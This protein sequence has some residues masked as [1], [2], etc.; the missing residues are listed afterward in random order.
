MLLQGQVNL[1]FW[2]ESSV[3]AVH[4]GRKAYPEAGRR[5]HCPGQPPR[6]SGNSVVLSS[7]L[8]ATI[9]TSKRRTT[10]SLP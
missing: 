2:R 3:P 8:S 5:P 7:S 9:G 10:G 1:A 4:A 6:E